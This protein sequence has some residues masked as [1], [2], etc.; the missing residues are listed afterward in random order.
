MAGVVKNKIIELWETME[1]YMAVDHG[2][3]PSLVPWTVRSD[4]PHEAAEMARVASLAGIGPMS[5]VAGLFAEEA[6]NDLLSRFYIRELVIENGG[7]LFLKLENDLLLSVYAGNSPLSGKIAVNIPA[8]ET[9]LGVCTSSGTVGPSLSFGQADAVMVAC[10]N[11]AQADAFATAFGNKVSSPDVLDEV[12]NHAAGY[13]EILSLVIIC[14][15]KAG[16]RGNFEVRFP[17]HPGS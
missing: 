13:P 8:G 7:D 14:R 2:F 5:A 9:P 12:L 15:D 4:A 11:S 3:A 10:K 6:G 1:N 17:G 16:I